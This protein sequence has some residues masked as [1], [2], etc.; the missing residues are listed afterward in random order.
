MLRWSLYVVTLGFAVYWASNLLLWFPWSFSAVLGMTLMLTVAPILWA[1]VTFLCLRSYPGRNPL[2]GSW[3][4]A[5]ILALLAVIMDYVFFGLIRNAME[6][7]YHPTTL[8]AYGFLISLPFLVGLLF[9]NRIR[10]NKRAPTNSD[11]ATAGVSGMICF[12]VL[13]LII[14][15]G[16][17]I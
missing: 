17:G 4:V 14:V 9:K 6:Q 5:A 7:L 8:Y 3:R 16:I 15:L 13:T 1:Y 10:R 11:F 12:G 2:G